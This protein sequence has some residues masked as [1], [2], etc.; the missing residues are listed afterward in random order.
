M[1]RR[2]FLKSGLMALACLASATLP[3]LSAS[4]S[5]AVPASPK[6]GTVPPGTM[7]IIIR[8]EC[9]EVTEVTEKGIWFDAPGLDCLILYQYSAHACGTLSYNS[10]TK[11]WSS[12]V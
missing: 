2:L 11:T 8:G 10:G 5:A 4:A 7:D 12:R 9:Y 6:L 3:I 1:R